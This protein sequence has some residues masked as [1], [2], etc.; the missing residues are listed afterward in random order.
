MLSKNLI[1]ENLLVVSK[2]KSDEALE[3][4][5]LVTTTLSWKWVKFVVTA[6]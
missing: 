6:V 2:Q 5:A 4:K 1:C 3:I